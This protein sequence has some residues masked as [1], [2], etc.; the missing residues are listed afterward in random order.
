MQVNLTTLMDLLIDQYAI[1]P[2]SITEGPRGFVAETSIVEAADG[3]RYFAKL[4]SPS[5]Q[6]AAT[7]RSLPVLEE[8]RAL[9][10]DTVSLPLRTRAGQLTAEFAGRTLILFEFIAGRGGHEGRYD[11]AQYVALLARIHR[12]TPQIRATLPRE[13]FGLPFAAEFA[14]HFA[15]ALREE[16]AISPVQ[17]ELRRLLLDHR[18]QI[19]ADLATLR[20]LAQECR[21]TPWSPTITHGDAKG[22]NLIVGADGRLYLI[23]W[24]DLLLAS[25]ERD[26]WFD[27]LG[28][29][30]WFAMQNRPPSAEFLR[31]YRQTFPAYQP[32]S[33]L[34]RFY[35]FRRFFEDLYG[36]LAAL[37]ENPPPARQT[38]LFTDLQE[39][40]FQWLW[41]AMRQP[42][43]A[44]P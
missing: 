2:V 17:V 5:T 32:D 29:G 3:R 30:D 21:R 13:D 35:L 42:P 40:C 39:T 43:P 37:A 9:G 41:P 20:S 28:E 33:S 22:D 10:I 11:F 8:F 18:E 38:R 36:Y 19:A 4:L 34:L 31:L 16:A 7:I 26:T 24:D 12:A 6:L 44:F 15:R 14:R 23:D 25:A 1:T 27:L